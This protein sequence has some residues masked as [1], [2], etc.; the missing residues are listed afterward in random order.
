MKVPSV[1]S[2]FY[3]R[4]VIIQCYATE[5]SVIISIKTRPELFLYFSN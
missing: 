3:N 5:Q 1:L 4:T 2:M